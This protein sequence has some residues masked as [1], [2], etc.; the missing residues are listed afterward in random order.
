MWLCALFITN[1][2]CH[3]MYRVGH[4]MKFRLIFV[5]LLFHQLDVK[6]VVNFRRQFYACLYLHNVY[7]V[8]VTTA[9]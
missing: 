3:D 2:V 9:A 6:L 4:T 8:S 7:C 1:D 5:K